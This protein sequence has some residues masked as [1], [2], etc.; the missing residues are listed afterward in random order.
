MTLRI[1]KV[2]DGHKTLIR[3]SGRLQPEHLDE[4]KR[5][6][7]DEQL[8][9]VLDLE[10]V[11][12]VDLE[13]VHFLDA[14]EHSGV[15]LLSC[16]R[17]IREWISREHAREGSRTDVK[18]IRWAV[19]HNSEDALPRLRAITQQEGHHD[20]EQVNDEDH[21]TNVDI[22]RPHDRHIDGSGG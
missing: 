12:L 20:E 10:G 19:Q 21:T 15:E 6:V 9:I 14:C 8:P 22:A 13:V 7:N 17:Y 4:L 18:S 11:M 2:A 3:L 5:Q 16:S 1:E